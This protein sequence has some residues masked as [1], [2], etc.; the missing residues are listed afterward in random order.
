[1]YYG[2]GEKKRIIEFA[3]EIAKCPKYTNKFVKNIPQNKIEQVF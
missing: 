2:N 1:M 3:H